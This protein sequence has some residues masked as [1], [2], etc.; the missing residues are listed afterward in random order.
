MSV[1]QLKNENCKTRALNLVIAVGLALSPYAD[2]CSHFVSSF[3]K[4]ALSCSLSLHRRKPLKWLYIHLTFPLK[5]LLFSGTWKSFWWLSTCCATTTIQHI[6]LARS[7]MP[8][9]LYL[10][11]CFQPVCCHKDANLSGVCSVP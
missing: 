2:L 6:D 5:S 1:K 10:L 4:A 8:Y 7:L 11:I 3:A 9:Q